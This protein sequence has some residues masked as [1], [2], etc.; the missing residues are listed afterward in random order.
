MRK[1]VFLPSTSGRRLRALLPRL[2]DGSRSRAQR[3]RAAW[4]VGGAVHP[5]G[6]GERPG[7]LCL[8]RRQEGGSKK[9]VS[10][11]QT[12]PAPSSKALEKPWSG[13]CRGSGAETAQ[14]AVEIPAAI[15]L[16]TQVFKNNLK[17]SQKYT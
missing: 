1:D 17:F 5:R 2:R 16:V 12:P 13:G 9:M 7:E 3:G 8:L 14:T 11:L 10:E 6:I 4:Q 15:L